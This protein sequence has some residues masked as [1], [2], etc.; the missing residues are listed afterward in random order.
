MAIDTVKLISPPVTEHVVEAAERLHGS[1]R[2]LTLDARSGELEQEFTESYLLGSYDA[3]ISLV[4]KRDKPIRDAEQGKNVSVPCEPYLV[5]ECSVHKVMLG[6][7]VYGGSSDFVACCRYLVNYISECLGEELPLA[8]DWEVG[9]VDTAEIFQLSSPEACKAWFQGLQLG[10][11]YRNRTINRYGKSSIH[12][13]GSFVCLKAYYKGDEFQKHDAKRLS[14]V[15]AFDYIKELQRIA[16]KTIR[17]EASIRRDKLV[18]DFGSKPLV[19][20]ITEDYLN[21]VY[22]KEVASFFRIGEA[23]AKTVNSIQNVKARL[24]EFFTP[25]R[26]RNLFT[27]WMELKL[28]GE[29]EVK[30]GMSSSTFHEHIRYLKEAGCCWH[31]TDESNSLVPE[32]FAPVRQDARRMTVVAPEIME[33]LTLSTSMTEEY[34]DSPLET[35]YNGCEVL[36]QKTKSCA[37]FGKYRILR[38]NTGVRKRL[39]QQRMT[40]LFELRKM[41]GALWSRPSSRVQQKNSTFFVFPLKKLPP[42]IYVYCKQIS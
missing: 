16:D 6:H 30:S 7:N 34:C 13:P 35:V 33:K 20:D 22:D 31:G 2:K 42:L 10:E 12:V 28:C 4:V 26:A 1:K 40:G 17:V 8:D 24:A 5:V 18:Y 19:K 27:T 11:T 37:D 23:K 21:S 29:S 15:M 38:N 41:I 25:R 9:Q 36:D 14:E 3:R 32:D 39:N